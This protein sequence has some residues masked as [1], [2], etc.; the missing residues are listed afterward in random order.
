MTDTPNPDEVSAYTYTN[1]LKTWF[2]MAI[3]QGMKL[4]KLRW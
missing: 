2:G 1:V 3:I 4:Q